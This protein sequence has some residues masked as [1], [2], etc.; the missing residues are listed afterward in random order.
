MDADQD[1]SCVNKVVSFLNLSLKLLFQ[2]V[3]QI[4][5]KIPEEGEK[6]KRLVELAKERNID[7][8]PSLEAQQSLNDYIDRK[9]LPNPGT[10]EGPTTTLVQINAVYN[11]PPVN[12][13][14]PPPN[15]YQPPPGGMGNF[16]P[17]Q[18]PPP[19]G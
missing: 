1:E 17:S 5:I 9:G 19:N 14:P 7:Y 15:N 8:K 16:P 2:I 11:P 3:A 10:G 6:I 18:M 12:H 4:N 13:L